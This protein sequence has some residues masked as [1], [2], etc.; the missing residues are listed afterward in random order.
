MEIDFNKVC[1]DQSVAHATVISICQ[2]LIETKFGE[3][4]GQLA[5]DQNIIQ[6]KMYNSMRRFLLKHSKYMLDINKSDSDH[7]DLNN[8][9][10]NS[11]SKE[12][13]HVKI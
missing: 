8:S 7:E 13:S 10:K 5:E 4:Y 11:Q 6:K 2:A 1:N 9:Q 12:D 3:R